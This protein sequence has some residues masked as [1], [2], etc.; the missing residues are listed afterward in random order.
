MA[1]HISQKLRRIL[2]APASKKNIVFWC[3]SPALFVVS[4][5]WAFIAYIY[6]S[7]GYLKL[8]ELNHIPSNLSVVCIGNVI[9]GGTGKTPI[10]RAYAEKYL[11][12]NVVVAIAARG[13]H[14]EAFF[15]DSLNYSIHDLEKLSD[16]NRE[17]FEILRSKYPDK[18]FYIYQNKN[19]LLSLQEF[20]K[21][22]SNF[23]S[24]PT[25]LFLMDDGLQHFA[26]PRHKNICV[27]DFNVDGVALPFSLPL[28]PYREGFGKKSL[29]KIISHFDA[30]FWPYSQTHRNTHTKN[31]PYVHRNNQSLLYELKIFKCMLVNQ[32]CQLEPT[33]VVDLQNNI[34]DKSL[35]MAGIAHPERFVNDLAQLN[36]DF[37]KL[38]TLFL[39]DHEDISTSI[40][41]Q[42]KPYTIIFLT[43]KDYFRFCSN[44]EFISFASTRIIYGCSPEYDLSSINE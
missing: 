39:A 22:L 3:L 24:M 18:H 4:A 12:N 10:V 1:E 29:Q 17:H 7:R 27:C 31:Y 19:R 30:C 41:N 6:R 28:G 36:N 26:C 33:R 38:K 25:A 2:D 9:I 34:S 23:T 35:I 42:L 11:K 40:L 43:L 32:S 16:E 37:L 20:I 5:L 44:K 15:L 13:I 8:I 14:K 21:V